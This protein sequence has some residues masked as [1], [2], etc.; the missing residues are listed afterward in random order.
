L[1]FFNH[2]NTSTF[3]PD[4][5]WVILSPIEQ[6][7]KQ[8]IESVGTPLKDWDISI[9]YGIKTGFNEAFIIDE[10]TKNRL[11]I[12]DPKSAEILRPILRGRDIKKY[13]A[14]FAGL[15]VIVAKFGSHKYLENDYPVIYNHLLKYKTQL[16]KRGQ[17]RYGGKNNAGMH[18]WLELDNCPSQNY[19][20]DFDKP[21][22]VWLTISDT[23]KFALDYIGY[24][25]LDSTFC[26]IFCSIGERITHE[27][28]GRKVEVLRWLKK[29]NIFIYNFR[30]ILI[31]KKSFTLK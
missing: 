24:Y 4:T 18:H 22:I 1:L 23:S 9:N 2:L 29:S 5:S 31:K 3:L 14:Q 28:S 12:E 21:K 20:N 30:T 10:E 7:I 27:V 6:N 19:L 13:T 15:W 25:C 26:F 11:I 17:C 16:E 8:K